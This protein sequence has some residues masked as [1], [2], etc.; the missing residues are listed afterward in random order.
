[1]KYTDDYR[2]G[3]L[4]PAITTTIYGKIKTLEFYSGAREFLEHS[5]GK[6]A[7]K[8]SDFIENQ[9]PRYIQSFIDKK[10]RLKTLE[11]KMQEY[12]NAFYSSDYMD[13]PSLRPKLVVSGPAHH[14]RTLISAINTPPVAAAG[15]DQAVI[16]V[17]STVQL[18]GS[19]TWDPEGDPLSYL[20]AIKEKPA[21]SN[22][23]LDDP[24]SPAPSFIADVHGNYRDV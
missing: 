12:M 11:H 23:Q 16:V 19:Q 4:F 18:D 5:D 20:W 17:G 8:I 14:P 13:D 9:L 22:A 3:E 21:G 1:M 7:G 2:F 6:V 10:E 24:G 15:E